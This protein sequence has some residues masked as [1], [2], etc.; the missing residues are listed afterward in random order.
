MSVAQLPAAVAPPAE[1]A[2]PAKAGAWL[3]VKAA[4]IALGTRIGRVQS[5]IILTI[6]YFVMIGPVALLYRLFADPLRM[7]RGKPVWRPR[8]PAPPDPMAWAR[9]QS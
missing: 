7:R 3:R 2:A 1:A 4:L 6:F 9:T 8:P 5:W